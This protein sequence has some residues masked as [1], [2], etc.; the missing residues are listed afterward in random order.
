MGRKKKTFY[1][2]SIQV[3]TGND[4]YDNQAGRIKA[5]NSWDDIEHDSED[6]YYEERGKILLDNNYSQKQDETESSEEEV[7]ALQTGGTLSEEDESQGENQEDD[8]MS[9]DADNDFDEFDSQTWGNHKKTYYDADEL[10]DF[11]EAKEEEE[12]ALRL[13]KKKISKMSEED[14]FDDDNLLGVGSISAMDMDKEHEKKLMERLNQEVQKVSFEKDD[15]ETQPKNQDHYS[16]L[17]RT[18]IVEILQDGSPELIELLSEFKEQ[19]STLKDTLAPIL[20][21]AKKRNIKYD[22]AMKFLSI[23]YHTLLNYLTNISFYFFL[24]SSG[25]RH[26]RMHPVIDTLVDLRT[27]LDKLETLESKMKD[28]IKQFVDRL[29]TDEHTDKSEKVEKE[30]GVGEIINELPSQIQTNSKFEK[31]KIKKKEKNES[32]K[33]K[34]KKKLDE[35]NSE[36]SKKTKLQNGYI[37]SDERDIN[38]SNM[39]DTFIEPEF[40]SFKNVKK[41]KRIREDLDMGDLDALDD[42]DAEDK[43]QNRKSLRHH[44]AKIDQNLAKREKAIRLG[45]DTDIPYKDK[46]KSVIKSVNSQNDGDDLDNLDWNE[47]DNKI[48]KDIETGGDDELYLSVRKTKKAKKEKEFEHEQLIKN[49]KNDETVYEEEMLPDGS[50]RQINYEIL[51]NKGLTPH[52]KKEQRNPRVKHRNKYEKAKKKIKSIK[53]IVVRQEGPYGG[54]ITGIKTKLSRSIKFND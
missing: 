12:E 49:S 34:R 27:T 28:I 43:A 16:N 44:V 4:K 9:S 50:K 38:L 31:V 35:E 15:S 25:T 37:R 48:A 18:E 26:L 13:Q 54:E 52:R 22:P 46:D 29:E 5:I 11:D 23:K 8:L 21:K 17:S 2:P 53:R 1:K 51:K 40:V 33:S 45:G 14:F 24:K 7:F 20:E 19:L 3:E 36:K 47:D 32:I 6:E 39:A 41:N 42:V 30:I 10:S